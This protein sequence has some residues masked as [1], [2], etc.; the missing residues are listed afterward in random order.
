MSYL[1]ADFKGKQLINFLSSLLTIINKSLNKC[2][3]N[4]EKRNDANCFGTVSN[5][6]SLLE[7]NE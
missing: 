4:D 6:N 1:K 3:A 2:R 7:G 5:A